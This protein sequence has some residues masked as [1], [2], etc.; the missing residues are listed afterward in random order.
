VGVTSACANN[1]NVAVDCQW[2]AY[3][4]RAR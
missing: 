1:S 2:W 3:M 4:K